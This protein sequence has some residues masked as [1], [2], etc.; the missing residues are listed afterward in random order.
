[1][2]QVQVRDVHAEFHGGRADQVGETAA[3]FPLLTGVAVL[4]AEAALAPLAF[5]GRDHLRRVFA[6]LQR[7]QRCGRVAV[8]A[9]EE[10]VDGWRDVGVTRA[11]ST[12]RIDRVRRGWAAIAHAPEQARRLELVAL[13]VV[14][15]LD[16]HEET[17]AEEECQ[18]RFKKDW[19]I[20]RAETEPLAQKPAERA[21]FVEA[22]SLHG[23]R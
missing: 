22:E 9:L 2:H 18:E 7:G 10:G 20:R 15:R 8:E 6:R 21:A 1:M 19:I 5:A 12:T 13:V 11:A 14:H 23:S 16:A 3:Q 4:P 17:L